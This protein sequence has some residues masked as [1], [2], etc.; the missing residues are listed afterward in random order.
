MSCEVKE[1]D[2]APVLHADQYLFL[3]HPYDWTSENYDE[4]DPRLVALNKEGYK[5]IWLG[6]DVCI[7]TTE[8]PET[9][10]YLDSV[11]GISDTNRV[12]W[13]LGNHDVRDGDARVIEEYT[14]RNAYN[15]SHRNGITMVV[16]NTNLNNKQVIET[17]GDVEYERRQVDF[18]RNVFDT[19]SDC[20]HLIILAHH[21][22]FHQ[23]PE[24]E[25]VLIGS[26]LHL[27]DY[28]FSSEISLTFQDFIYPYLK[29]IRSRGVKIW[30]VTGDVGTYAKGFHVR[31]DLGI[32]YLG[33]GINNSVASLQYF[34]SYVNNFKPDKVLVFNHLTEN[35]G[36]LIPLF[37][38]LDS[39]V[40][41]QGNN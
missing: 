35:G 16:L 3:G 40:F 12:Y 21:T 24:F 9:M 1:K 33:S 25:G 27:D 2:F 14:G 22:I 38:N 36:Q 4:V 20:Q 34:P 32:N 11:F 10:F 29:A 39:L 5:E 8:R 15:V 6:G 26:N 41:E 17:V 7:K 37:L 28:S 19:I 18:I 13:S 30:W 23:L 31:D